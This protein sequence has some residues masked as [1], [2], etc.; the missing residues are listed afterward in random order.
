MISDSHSQTHQPSTEWT[1]LNNISLNLMKLKQITTYLQ[2]HLCWWNALY[3][4]WLDDQDQLPT[5]DW[6]QHPCVHTLLY[7]PCNRPFRE[8]RHWQDWHSSCHPYAVE[9]AHCSDKPA[10]SMPRCIPPQS[11]L[12]TLQTAQRNFH[13]VKTKQQFQKNTRYNYANT[14]NTTAK[15]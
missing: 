5:M 1:E 6:C 8:Y 12:K 3:R 13:T 15:M 7:C 2:Y 14:N 11:V 10:C 4:L 9:S